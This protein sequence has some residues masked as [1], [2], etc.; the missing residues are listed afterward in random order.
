MLGRRTV[1]A[2]AIAAAL[3]MLSCDA[4]EQSATDPTSTAVLSTGNT[5][6]VT[7][8]PSD[9]V[10]ED[11]HSTCEIQAL[12]SRVT[13][14]VAGDEVIARG[15]SDTEYLGTVVE[16]E[17][18]APVVLG[19][20]RPPTSPDGG[21]GDP[22]RVVAASSHPGFAEIV[23]F[24][25]QRTATPVVLSQTLP[26]GAAQERAVALLAGEILEDGSL[27]LFGQCGRDFMVSV[28][29]VARELEVPADAQ[30]FLNLGTPGTKESS[31]LDAML[32]G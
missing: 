6:E 30:M 29:A 8:A 20:R 32:G 31:A 22:G 1:I 12:L 13:D 17:I 10:T 5:A 14:V 7:L 15:Y 3:P 2:L 24:E 9:A 19:S 25:I 23:L 27:S 16:L 11:G 18:V 26:S 4:S 28:R 21:D